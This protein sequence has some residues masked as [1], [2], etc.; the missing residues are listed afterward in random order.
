M[1]THQPLSQVL[2]ACKGA[3][4]IFW[5]AA[6][7]APAGPDHEIFLG[8][9]WPEIDPATPGSPWADAAATA[10]VFQR[11]NTST[12]LR[13][14]RDFELWRSSL[15]EARADVPWQTI[16]ARWFAIA[17][18]EFRR[19]QRS[20]DFLAAVARAV[21]VAADHLAAMTPEQRGQFRG[22]LQATARARRAVVGAALTVVE[23][24][25]TPKQ[26]I[27][28]LGEIT[29]SRYAPLTRGP[30]PALGPVL[31]CHGLIGRQ[32]MTDLLPERSMVRQLLTSGVDVFVLD[33][34]GAGQD[35]QG[36]D[37][38]AIARFVLP[39]ALDRVI[40]ES[41]AARAILMG[42][43]QGGTLAAVAATLSQQKLAGLITA[44]APFDFHADTEDTDPSHGLM[45]LWTRAPALE[46]LERLLD[47]SGDLPGARVQ[48]CIRPCE[49]SGSSVSA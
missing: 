46:D 30:N 8:A 16:R 47:L 24:A 29:V 4:Q 28:R 9:D 26:Q 44:V 18:A 25:A 11:L 12:W 33:W 36:P 5:S 10:Q 48:R 6:G 39:A 21:R 49:G 23:I 31:I 1:S 27:W 20:D 45:H 37:L 32:T 42:I 41:G 17:E 43:C 19:T 38:D 15:G 7:A 14:A 35:R 22:L 13:I 2:E 34:G 40:A 3:Q